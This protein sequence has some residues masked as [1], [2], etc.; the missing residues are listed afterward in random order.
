M[1]KLFIISGLPSSGS[2]KDS[3]IE[4]LKKQIEFNW[5]ITTTT[6]P[7]R[8]GEKQGYPYHFV[9]KS[10]FE[11]M[12]DQGEFLE[13]ALVYGNYYGNSRQAVEQALKG[14]GPVV[15]RID[16]QGVRTYKKLMPESIVILITVSSIKVL[17]KR[18]RDR[19]QDSEE[20]IQRRLVAAKKELD[21]PP[22]YDYMVVNKQGKLDKTVKKV[23]KIILKES[24]K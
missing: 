16:C 14:D 2:G 23:K 10:E 6:R 9:S 24:R 11:K 5:V 7:M 8:S 4:G 22:P 21:N 13:W 12:R 19:G 15:L 17:E 3:V 18:L 20:V 1:S